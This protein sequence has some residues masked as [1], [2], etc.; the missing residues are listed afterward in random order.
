MVGFRTRFSKYSVSG[1]TVFLEFQSVQNNWFIECHLVPDHQEVL[2]YILEFAM[3]ICTTTRHTRHC[4][5]WFSDGP[6]RSRSSS[7]FLPR[8]MDFI[9]GHV[10]D[11]RTRASWRHEHDL[12]WSPSDG[13]G[14]EC[15]TASDLDCLRIRL[16]LVSRRFTC[17]KAQETGW[18]HRFH[19]QS[20]FKALCSFLEVLL[21]KILF[22]Y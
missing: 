10:R 14:R 15:V 6:G 20:K 8:L 22:E 21:R 19:K 13:E 7:L 1:S 2:K 9:Q 4:I 16:H 18:S 5:A 17:E 11:V 3:L 12:E